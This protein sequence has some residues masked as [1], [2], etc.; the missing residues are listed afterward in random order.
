LLTE[1]QTDKRR[2]KH[3]FLGGGNNSARDIHL[4]QSASIYQCF[5][6]IFSAHAQKLFR[7]SSQKNWIVF[8]FSDPDFLKKDNNLS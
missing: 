7:A 5:G 1:R 3:D 4:Q 6:L 8:R 2:V